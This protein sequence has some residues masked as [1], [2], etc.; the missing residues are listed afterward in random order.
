MN[1]LT[2]SE[3]ERSCPPNEQEPVRCN[4]IAPTLAKLGSVDMLTEGPA[5]GV[6]DDIFSGSD[7]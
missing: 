5:G 6:Q 7:T 2:R 4:Y 3:Q 1:L